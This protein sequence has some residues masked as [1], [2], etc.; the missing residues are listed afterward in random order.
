MASLRDAGLFPTGSLL[1]SLDLDTPDKAAVVRWRQDPRAELLPSRRA[2]ALVR[3]RGESRAVVVELESGEVLSNQTISGGQVAVTTAEVIQTIQKAVGD[4]R[5]QEALKK[6][7]IERFGIDSLFC[8]PRTVGN[9]GDAV[10]QERRIVKADCFDLRD[11]PSNIFAAPI[12]GLFATVDLDSGEVIEVTDLGGVPPARGSHSLAPDSQPSLR[13]RSPAPQTT[14]DFQTN[15]SIVTWEKWR[16]HI[17]WSTHAGLVVSDVS[18]QDGDQRRSVLYEGHLSELYVPYMD[19]T[20]G[21][22]FRNYF[23]EGDYGIGTTASK[24]V[25]GSDCPRGASYFS[26]LATNAVGGVS[27][28]EDR[29]CVF[30]RSTGEPT[31]RH[32]DFLSQ[33]LDS[34]PDRELIVR[35]IATVGNYDYLFDWIFDAKGRITFR[36]GA[37]GLDAVKAVAAQ[38]LDDPTAARDT[39]WGPLIAAGRA[40]IHHDHFFSL[41]LDVDIDGTENRFVKDELYVEEQPEGSRRKSLWRVR[42]R[43]L[44][45]DSDAKLDIDL[46]RPSLWRVQNPE[47]KNALGY[48]SSYQLR[49]GA[50]ALPLVDP[51]DSPLA[52]AGFANHHLWVTPYSRD[53]R[54]AAG[55]F[56]NQAPG[57]LGLP[58]WTASGRDI[59]KKDI[60]LWYTMGFHHVPSAEDWPVYNVGWHSVTLAPYNFFDHNPAM[61][62]PE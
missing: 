13:K 16:F 47:R 48:P 62:L 25:D 30:E 31:W 14:K 60:V 3:G 24:L 23:D 19:P 44:D 38:T 42:E 32:F 9:F 11:N 45:R 43:V 28:L 57:G 58:A 33:Q 52:R 27:P 50:N 54:W 10:E 12:E 5:M 49:S 37:T 36:G 15:G 4:P 8:A 46:R 41:R 34:R 26:P 53:E 40:G 29:I 55:E 20:E 39:E 1:V 17:G 22:Y 6:R 18:Y 21:W 56:P 35:F 7:G 2:R 51:T 61:D 59:D